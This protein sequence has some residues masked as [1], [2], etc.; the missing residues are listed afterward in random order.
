ML[1]IL[2]HLSL[3][4]WVSESFRQDIGQF[5]SPRMKLGQSV[6]YFIKVN[7]HVVVDI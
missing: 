3:L 4:S 5:Q 2:T 6:G 1:W 7:F